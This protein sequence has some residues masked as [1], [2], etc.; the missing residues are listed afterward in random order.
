MYVSFF[1]LSFL[2]MDIID[3]IVIFRIDDKIVF[4][5]NFVVGDIFYLVFV[6]CGG[7]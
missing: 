4:E 3:K 1:I 2:I 7:C 5:Y 6:L